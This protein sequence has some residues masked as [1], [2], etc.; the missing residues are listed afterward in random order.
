MCGSVVTIEP[1]RISRLAI[2]NVPAPL[3]PAGASSQSCHASFHQVQRLLELRSARRFGDWVTSAFEPRNSSAI[4]PPLKTRTPTTPSATI[5][6]SNQPKIL[7]ARS[8]DSAGMPCF[9]THS[10]DAARASPIKT[11]MPNQAPSFTRSE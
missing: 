10:P 8:R 7:V 1:T 5:A 2:S 6:A 4:A 3:P 9:K 11:T